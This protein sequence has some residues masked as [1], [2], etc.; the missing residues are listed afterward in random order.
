VEKVGGGSVDRWHVV[1]VLVVCHAV[2]AE[3]FLDPGVS[4]V[5]GGGGRHGGERE[6]SVG[7]ADAEEENGS[8]WELAADGVL[9]VVWGDLEGS[10]VEE[11]RWTAGKREG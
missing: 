6:R 5:T 4:N 1:E 3:G 9:C 11:E 7:D 2:L 10:E 8:G